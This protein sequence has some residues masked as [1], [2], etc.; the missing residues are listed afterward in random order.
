MNV[1]VGAGAASGTDR[2]GI[3]VGRGLRWGRG[4]SHREVASPAGGTGGVDVEKHQDWID[5]DAVERRAAVCVWGGGS[6]LFPV[7]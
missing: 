1:G 7:C 5:A 6:S 4:L 3:F 2:R